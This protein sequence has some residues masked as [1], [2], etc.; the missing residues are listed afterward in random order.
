M[1]IHYYIFPNPIG[2]RKQFLAHECENAALYHKRH[3][4]LSAAFPKTGTFIS[5]EFA[6]TPISVTIS[7][8]GKTFREEGQ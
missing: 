4:P 3:D 7:T 2:P 5:L 1:L 6:V 8:T